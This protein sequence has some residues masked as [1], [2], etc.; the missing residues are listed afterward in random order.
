MLGLGRN[1]VDR[2]QEVGASVSENSDSVGSTSFRPDESS[3]MGSSAIELSRFVAA[4][5]TNL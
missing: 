1:G 4:C 2:K 5:L 3:R